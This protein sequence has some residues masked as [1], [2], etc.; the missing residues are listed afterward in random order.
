MICTYQTTWRHIPEDRGFNIDRL[1]TSDM[2]SVRDTHQTDIHFPKCLLCCCLGPHICA[3]RSCTSS[4]RYTRGSPCCLCSNQSLIL[5]TSRH[6]RRF[7]G[8]SR[9][10]TEFGMRSAG[11]LCSAT[12]SEQIGR[13]SRKEDITGKTWR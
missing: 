4:L 5:P 7:S 1:R 9:E 12:E 6:R 3:S 10:H 11:S 2:S 13:K 8:P